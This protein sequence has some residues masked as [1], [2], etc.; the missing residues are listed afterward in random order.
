MHPLIAVLINLGIIVLVVGAL[1]VGGLWAAR[2]FS[3]AAPGSEL[4]KAVD[5]TDMASA[6]I[7]ALSLTIGAAVS[8]IAPTSGLAIWLSSP[9]GVFL[10][11]VG[12]AAVA[13]AL[14]VALALRKHLAAR[15][16]GSS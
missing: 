14:R 8:V 9:L 15:R 13:I 7:I 16:D 11:L 5:S 4:S 3:R 10:A 1:L 6:A 12:V 2:R